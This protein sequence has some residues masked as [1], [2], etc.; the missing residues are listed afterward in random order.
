MTKWVA[1]YP[2][3]ENT[4]ITCIDGEHWYFMGM[5][6]SGQVRVR[7]HGH[8]NIHHFEADH[9]PLLEVREG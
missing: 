7:K 2:V 1:Y 4:L 6:P 8:R 3:K 5:S 9:F